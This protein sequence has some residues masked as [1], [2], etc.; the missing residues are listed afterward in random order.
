[1]KSSQSKKPSLKKE[2]IRKLPDKISDHWQKI[3]VIK[4]IPEP[5][6]LKLVKQEVRSEIL[7]VLRKGI[8]EYDEK[9]NLVEIR[10]VFSAKELHKLIKESLS[11]KIKISNV[12]FHLN[13]LI[14]KGYVQIVTSIKE[15]R[16]ITHF[17]GR[18][19]RL[20]LWMG[21]PLD[22][23]DV[24]DES[25]F[26]DFII[27]LKRFNPD[28]TSETVN[29]LFRSFLQVRQETH[30]RAKRWMEK[31]LE[32]VTEL[33]VDTRDVYKFLMSIDRCD[34]KTIE[35]YN[36]LMKLLNFPEE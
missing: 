27:I 26:S 4:E 12:Y 9:Q 20:F 3:P 32:I 1:M 11:I 22:T 16:Q 29:N 30:D 34:S 18:T 28:L 33:N 7:N 21:E 36:K 31:N 2:R 14:D 19:A 15:G 25:K 35:T 6:P 24:T 5:M 17:Y 8:E 23:T 13:K 10:H